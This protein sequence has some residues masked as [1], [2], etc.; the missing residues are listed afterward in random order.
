[1]DVYKLRVKLQGCEFE[2]EG[3]EE[4][5][6]QQFE[7]FKTLINA[8]PPSLRREEHA[9]GG[10]PLAKALEMVNIFQHD[11]ELQR[12]KLIVPPQGEHKDAEAA[13][14]LLYAYKVMGNQ[15]EVRVTT[16]KQS[17]KD[18]GRPVKRVDRAIDPYTHDPDLFV[19]PVGLEGKGRR[20]RLTPQGTAKAQALCGALVRLVG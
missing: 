13:L 7:E 6:K 10:P 3:P 2:A 12:I 20:Y 5:V 15:D 14:L 16:L 17:L 4:I 8:A 18:S 19:M 9:S 11:E 1:M